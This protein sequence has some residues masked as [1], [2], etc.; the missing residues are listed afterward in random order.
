MLQAP[1]QVSLVRAP[2]DNDMGGSDGTSHAA[3][4]RGLGLDRE[5]VTKSCT[6]TVKDATESGITIQV[7]LHICRHT[8]KAPCHGAVPEY[9]TESL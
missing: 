5:L 3:R 1:A 6:V 7:S 2:T 8:L 9:I 4:W